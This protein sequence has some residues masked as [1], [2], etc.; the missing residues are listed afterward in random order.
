MNGAVR[1]YRRRAGV[2]LRAGLVGVGIL[3]LGG[4]WLPAAAAEKSA[5]DA[6][7]VIDSSGSMKWTDPRRLRVPA[8]KIFLSLLGE[9]DRVGIISFSDNGY[10]VLGLTPAGKSQ[11]A[12]LFAAVEKVSEKGAYTNLHAALAKGLD[13][14]AREGDP[15]RRRMLLLMTDGK[16][17]TGDWAQ[18]RDLAEKIRSELI[19]HAVQAGVEVYTIAFTEASDMGLMQE[20]AERTAALSRL[21][22]NDRDLHEVFSQIFE[23]A[24]QPD[25]L[26][27]Q[28]GRFMIDAAVEEITIVASKAAAEVKI[29]LE[30]PDGRRLGAA[31][32]GSGARW[33]V[34][35]Q[36]DMITIERPL[37]GGWRLVSS[38]DRGDRAYVVTQ[39]GLDGRI[40]ERPIPVGA[41]QTAE[42]WLHENAVVLDKPEI[43]AQTR[44][45]LS[46]TDP[47]GE[48]RTL[49]LGDAG[50]DGDASA[51]D[52][53][54]ATR[55]EFAKP[56]QHRVHVAAQNPNFQREK[57][58]IL[59][60]VAPE[61]GTVPPPQEPPAAEPAA[62]AEATPEPPVP[63]PPAA[64]EPIAEA[65]EPEPAGVN[66][67]LLI[68]LFVL[69]NL[70]VAA[71]VGGVIF[72]RRRK[73][74]KAAAAA[75]VEDEAE[76]E[77]D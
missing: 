49:S 61:P 64:D 8:A 52:G 54:F 6:V 45:T 62:P 7:L 50:A 9:S 19:E 18:D 20:I 36:F 55:L 34:S 25:R 10:P 38:D 12:R 70:L 75:P 27:I 13:M 15:Q 5:I 42:A 67:G 16:M 63:A 1:G 58:W 35:E 48:S 32:A 37:A 74:A 66:I 30:M 77:G 39:L 29:S 2:L 76:G 65:P 47:D 46:V 56:G 14:L 24:K 11:Q 44:F 51:D 41:P 26:P 17:D 57:T 43:L 28:G 23:S 72:W 21:A 53:R 59:D 22:S 60:V 33:F 71:A 69:L 73:A 40:G 3:L 4:A 68:S 31:T